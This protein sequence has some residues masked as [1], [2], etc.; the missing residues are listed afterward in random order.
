[1]KLQSLINELAAS[2]FQ[3]EQIEAVIAKLK[4]TSTTITEEQK[5]EILKG[6]GATSG[7]HPSPDNE[8]QS[9]QSG[10]LTEAAPTG[11]KESVQQIHAREMLSRQSIQRLEQQ[12]AAIVGQ[13]NAIHE[14]TLKQ[15]EETAYNATQLELKLAKIQRQKEMILA[16][17]PNSDINSFLADLGIANPLTVC[18]D[19]VSLAEQSLTEI[20]RLHQEKKS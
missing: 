8:R 4:L 15:T 2:G 13:Q 11:I 20:E 18:A 3:Y 5:H 17:Q 12:Y 6:L 19:A 7:N 14:E 16:C 1:M 9:R 10:G